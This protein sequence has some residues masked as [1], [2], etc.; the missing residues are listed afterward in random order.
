MR[1]ALL[2]GENRDAPTRIEGRNTSTNR[3]QTTFSQTNAVSSDNTV[4]CRATI[5]VVRLTMNRDG[6]IGHDGITDIA[7]GHGAETDTPKKE[8]NTV[9]VINGETG[10]DHL[11]ADDGLDR[12]ENL[13]VSIGI[14]RLWI[15]TKT[16]SGRKR[17]KRDRMPWKI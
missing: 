14:D 11:Q 10:L 1:L 3:D 13:R 4:D 12:P 15:E 8:G 17:K 2:Q 9:E 6:R 5:V 7:I 16:A